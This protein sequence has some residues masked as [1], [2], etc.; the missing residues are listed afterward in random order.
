MSRARF[1]GRSGPEDSD[2]N[3]ITVIKVINDT[4]VTTEDTSFVVGD[5]PA[6]FDVNTALGRNGTQFQVFNDGA[7]DI[8]VSISNDGA[9]FGNEHSVQSEE[10]YVIN[11]ISVDS[12]RITHTGTDSAYRVLAL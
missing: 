6:T 5:S 1:D 12:I 2:G 9:V 3:Q 8:D 11:N 10:V 7:G 4:P